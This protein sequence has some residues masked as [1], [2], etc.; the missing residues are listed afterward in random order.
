MSFTP[1]FFGLTARLFLIPKRGERQFNENKDKVYHC[2]KKRYVFNPISMIWSRDNYY[3]LGY[4]DKHEGASRY[5][6]DKMED[7]R[8]EEESRVEKEEFKDFDPDAYRKQVFSMFGGRLEKVTIR[9]DPEL[10]GDI[11]DKF[12]TDLRI[13][14]TADGM[15]RTTFEIQVSKTFFVWVVGTLG[16]VKIVEP[17]NVKKE[18]N[19]FVEQIMENY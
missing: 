3:L 15:F 14:K 12:G 11:Y 6:I 10:L 17:A 13:Q 16:K 1:Y 18:F 9:F 2:D 19:A 4:D 5:R 8:V 7:V